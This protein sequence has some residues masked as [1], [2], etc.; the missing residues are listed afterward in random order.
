LQGKAPWFSDDPRLRAAAIDE[1]LRHAMLG[2]AV[3]SERA[4]DAWAR[5]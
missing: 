4:Q 3:P 2:E 1:T 5:S